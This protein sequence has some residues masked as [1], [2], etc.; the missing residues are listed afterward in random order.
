M[1]AG[2]ATQR[3]CT[4]APVK[5]TCRCGVAPSVKVLGARKLRALA[6]DRSA[7]VANFARLLPRFALL[8]PPRAQFPPPHALA[9]RKAAIP[10]RFAASVRTAAE[11]FPRYRGARHRFDDPLPPQIRSSSFAIRCCSP[12]SRSPFAVARAAAR[13]VCPADTPGNPSY[14]YRRLARQTCIGFQ[15]QDLPD[16]QTRRDA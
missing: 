1:T 10:L 8:Q 16:I 13:R 4:L 11:Y 6:A 3:P 5:R 12:A 2:Q 14:P 15:C 7:R 9:R